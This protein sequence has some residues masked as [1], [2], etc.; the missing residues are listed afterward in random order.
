MVIHFRVS[1]NV[2][3][4]SVHSMIS[5]LQSGGIFKR[6]AFVTWC[7]YCGVPCHRRGAPCHDA[8]KLRFDASQQNKYT[9][10]YLS[11]IHI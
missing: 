4:G 6:I 5:V 10:L 8:I 2:C 9:V 3:K 11:L 7:P 1:I